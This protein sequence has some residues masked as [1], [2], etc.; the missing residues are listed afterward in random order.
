MLCAM[1]SRPILFDQGQRNGLAQRLNKVSAANSPY[2]LL[3]ALALFAN[4]TVLHG[5]AQTPAPD[6]ASLDE[7]SD[8]V[9]V[10]PKGAPGVKPDAVA[11]LQRHCFDAN[12]LHG[13]SLIPR[14]DP[15]WVALDQQTRTQFGLS[16]ADT[17]AFGLLDEARDQTL[18]IKF[19]TMELEGG[20]RET[21]CTMAVIGGRDHEAFPGRLTSLFRGQGTRRHVGRPNGAQKLPGWRQWLWTAMPNRRSKSWQ[22][23]N[24]GRRGSDADGWIVVYDNHLFYSTYNYVLVDL[25]TRDDPARRVSVMTF[26]HTTRD[27][28]KK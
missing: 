13:Q 15:Q 16:N 11:Y 2:Q 4:A 17:P 8:I 6:A 23:I 14:D 26:A 3:T 22:S 9:V 25:K 12:R 24:A 7:L 5:Q 21:R 1:I 19:E 18:L 20:L 28:G 27:K 10:A